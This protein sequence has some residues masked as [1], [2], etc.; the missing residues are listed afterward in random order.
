MTS[1]LYCAAAD[2]YAFGLPRGSIPNPGRSLAS[3]SDTADSLT[4]DQHGLDE[5]TAFRLR[6]DASG[7]MP[8]GLTAGTTYYAHPLDESQFQARSAPEGGPIVNITSAGD[9]ER[10]ILIVPLDVESWIRWASRVVDEMLPAHVVPLATPYPEVIVI[11]TAELAAA[12]GLG[13]GGASS[14]SLAKMRDDAEKRLARWASGLPVRNAP[15]QTPANMATS[16]AVPYR[17]RRGWSR[18]GGTE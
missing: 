14:R 15:D 9:A 18:Y 5:D 16:A 8:G 6:A 7:A 17:D 11:T 3:V 12:K 1:P 10:V 13:V 2:L 4:L